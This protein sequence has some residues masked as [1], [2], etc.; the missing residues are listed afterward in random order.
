LRKLN[1]FLFNFAK[2]LILSDPRPNEE[3]LI[4]YYNTRFIKLGEDHYI[5][6]ASYDVY[7]KSRTDDEVGNGR[8]HDGDLHGVRASPRDGLWRQE[9]SLGEAAGAPAHQRVGVGGH[10]LP[11]SVVERV[12]LVVGPREGELHVVVEPLAQP[13]RGAGP[14]VRR[15]RLRG[16]QGLDLV[17]RAAGAVQADVGRHLGQARGVG[18]RA[19]AMLVQLR[20]AEVVVDAS[21]A[22]GRRQACR[23]HGRVDA[24]E[25][26]PVDGGQGCY[27][28]EGPRHAVLPA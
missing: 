11:R 7:L 21:V 16:E 19:V 6:D 13:Q 25:R 28:Q 17:H 1:I 26:Q 27:H 20:H 10:L 4:W 8:A 24:G 2:D 23:H 12:D 15:R 5:L 9:P 22:V 18:A 14:G 3:A